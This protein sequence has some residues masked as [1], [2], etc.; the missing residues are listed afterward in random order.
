MSAG[1]GVRRYQRRWLTNV[2]IG[3]FG[4]VP[5]IGG[6]ISALYGFGVIAGPPRATVPELT[7]AGVLAAFGIAAGVRSALVAVYVTD[8]HLIVRNFWLTHRIPWTEIREIGRPR[9]FTWAG[10]VTAMMNLRNG[11]GILIADGRIRVATA[12]TPAGWD[13]PDFADPVIRALRAELSHHQR[14]HKQK[15]EHHT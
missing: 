4:G 12:Y 5:I 6:L 15:H 7:G 11:I 9:P 14:E 2:W 8:E 3:T 1:T 13:P 10:R